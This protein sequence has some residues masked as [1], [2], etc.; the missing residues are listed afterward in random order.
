LPRVD[1]KAVRRKAGYSNSF[2]YY[3][4]CQS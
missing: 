2:L 1:V 4:H 3:K